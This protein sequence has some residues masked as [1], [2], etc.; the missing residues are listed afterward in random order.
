MCSTLMPK[1]NL[2]DRVTQEQ[3][4]ARRQARTFLTT[5]T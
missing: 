4:I 2:L 1:L 3:A 5:H